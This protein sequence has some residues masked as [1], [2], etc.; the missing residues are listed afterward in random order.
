M[1]SD[2]I[3][4][5]LKTDIKGLI[6]LGIST[7]IIAALIY[8]LTKK[9]ISRMAIFIRNKLHLNKVKR[10]LTNYGRGYAAGYANTSTYRQIV[11]VGDFIIKV[12]LNVG[13]I[14]FTTLVFVSLLLL[15]GQ[16]FTWIFV[17]VFSAIIGFQYRKLKEHIALY[18]TTIELVF[19]KEFF[20]DQK[21]AIKEYLEKD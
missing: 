11:F 20:K 17:I 10:E 4:N 21:E 6:I 2:E 12:V 19:G 1:T 14:L 13:W 15:M 8:D 3:I 5:F 18:Q 16:S 9:Q 7:S